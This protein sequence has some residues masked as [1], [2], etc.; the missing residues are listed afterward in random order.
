MSSISLRYFFS[1][2]ISFFRF[3]ILWVTSVK[4]VNTWYGFFVSGL[5]SGTA[6]MLIQT[7]SSFSLWQT[8]INTSLTI[9]PVRSDTIAGCSSPGKLVPSS[10]IDRQPGSTDFLPCIWSNDNPNISSAALLAFII[11]PFAFW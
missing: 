7:R 2:S 1:L 9:F 4:V 10:F 8:P 6:C 11:S 5:N 3:I